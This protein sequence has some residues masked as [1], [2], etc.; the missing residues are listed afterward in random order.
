MT[1]M[2][3]VGATS[4]LQSIDVKYLCAVKTHRSIHNTKPQPPPGCT[5]PTCLPVSHLRPNSCHELPSFISPPRTNA[6]TCVIE[7]VAAV[8]K[9]Y[10]CL[11]FMNSVLN[12]T[13]LRLISHNI[14]F[15]DAHFVIRV[16]IIQHLARDF[17][18]AIIKRHKTSSLCS[19]LSRYKLNMYNYGCPM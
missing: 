18:A 12:S 5:S 6:T 4:L 16:V 7:H 9:V 15:V 13:S 19:L 10:N 1:T 17:T 3:Q 8:Q 14:P 11:V 2:L